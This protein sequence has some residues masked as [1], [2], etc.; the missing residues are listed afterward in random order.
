M[1][2]DIILP[3]MIL[4][5]LESPG[6]REKVTWEIISIL[7]MGKGTNMEL[8]ND[9]N[10]L[11]ILISYCSILRYFSRKAR[12]SEIWKKNCETAYRGLF[13]YWGRCESTHGWTDMDSSQQTP[14]NFLVLSMDVKWNKTKGWLPEKASRNVSIVHSWEQFAL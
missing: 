6:S 1:D 7:K 8:I 11:L 2:P 10:F 4:R 12:C 5:Y 13:H 9:A 3:A 14:L